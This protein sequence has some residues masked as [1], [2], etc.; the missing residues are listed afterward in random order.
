MINRMYLNSIDMFVKDTAELMQA[1]GFNKSNVMGISLGGRIA[2][3]LTLQHPDMVNKLMLVSTGARVHHNWLRRLLTTP[4]PKIFYRGDYPQPRYA[5]MRQREASGDYDA[6]ER[7]KLIKAP[8][9]I[10]HGK[11]DKVMPLSMAEEMHRDIKDSEL[12]TFKGGHLFFLIR[13]RQRFLDKAER[14]LS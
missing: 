9:I 2:L 5:F 4:P 6:T 1:T 14:F 13:E 7:L 10:M 8:T 12:R 11:S 3:E